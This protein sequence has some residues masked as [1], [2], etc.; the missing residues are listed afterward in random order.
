MVAKHRAVG[1]G[2]PEHPDTFDL[3]WHAAERQ[4]Y[5]V[6]TGIGGRCHGV[7]Q[8]SE[9]TG[10]GREVDAPHGGSDRVRGRRDHIRPVAEARYRFLRCRLGGRLQ[11][12]AALPCLHQPVLERVLKIIQNHCRRDCGK[13]DRFAGQLAR[14]TAADELAQRLVDLRLRHPGRLG[15][16]VAGLRGRAKQADVAASFVLREAQGHQCLGEVTSCRFCR[17]GPLHHRA[18][19]RS[20][21]QTTGV[22]GLVERSRSRREVHLTGGCARRSATRSFFDT[23]PNGETGNSAYA[24]KYSGSLCRASS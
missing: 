20:S 9:F 6:D 1:A 4:N 10:T 14:R 5:H 11:V 8:R 7:L 2:V 16:G 13:P 15:H 22:G 24:C 3:E 19:L 21:L 12:G 18:S 17:P 23:F